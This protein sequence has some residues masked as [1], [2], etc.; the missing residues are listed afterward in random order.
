VLRETELNEICTD[1]SALLHRRPIVGRD[2]RTTHL[3]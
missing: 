1:V 3:P 2:A